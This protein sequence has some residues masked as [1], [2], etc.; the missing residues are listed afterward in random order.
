MGRRSLY[1]VSDFGCSTVVGF[2]ADTTV[3]C[4][5]IV[6]LPPAPS[7]GDA[8]VAASTIG[9]AG[10]EECSATEGGVGSEAVAEGAASS[11]SDGGY[12]AP[13]VLPLTSLM[14]AAPAS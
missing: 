2:C 1:R 12:Q 4:G 10:M 5:S 13:G 6:G 14:L 9:K 8:V 11:A 3:I 7:A